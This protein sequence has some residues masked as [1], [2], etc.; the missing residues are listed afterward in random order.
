MPRAVVFTNGS[1]W[2]TQFV[3]VSFLWLQLFSLL[4]VAFLMQKDINNDNLKNFLKEHLKTR[5][6]QRTPSSIVRDSPA[7]PSL[8]RTPSLVPEDKMVMIHNDFRIRLN[9][10][11]PLRADSSTVVVLTWLAVFVELCTE[12]GW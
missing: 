3:Q 9:M 12:C 10:C 5:S 8:M 2:P 6:S 11:E 1:W 4:I 7:P